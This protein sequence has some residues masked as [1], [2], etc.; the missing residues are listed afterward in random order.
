MIKHLK[1]G[2]T[3]VVVDVIL[4]EKNARNLSAIAKIELYSGWVQMYF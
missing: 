4:P 2:V 1:G 3:H